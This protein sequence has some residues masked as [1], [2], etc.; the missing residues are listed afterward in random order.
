MSTHRSVLQG[1]RDVRL[2]LWEDGAM[3]CGF[4]PYECMSRMVSTQAS[5]YSRLKEENRLDGCRGNEGFF[6]VAA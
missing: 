2:Q 1:D 5:D 6:G 4:R 3:I